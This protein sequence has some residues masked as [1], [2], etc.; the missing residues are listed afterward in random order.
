MTPHESNRDVFPMER[1]SADGQPVIEVESDAEENE[2]EPLKVKA[3]VCMPSAAEVEEHR[4]THLPYRSWCRECVEGRALG[5]KRYCQGRQDEHKIATIGIDYFYMT[6]HSDELL[7]R[8][9]TGFSGTPEG[10]A[11]LAQAIEHGSVVKCV[12][13]KCSA[14]KVITA[15]VV[16]AKG[17]D[18]EGFITRLIVKDIEWIGH[19][20]FLLKADNERSLQRLVRNAMRESKVI[21]EDVDTVAQENPEAYESQSNGM[22]ESAIKTLRGMFRTLRACLQRRLQRK[23]PVSHPISAWLLEHCCM[24]LNTVKR[25]DDG[26]TA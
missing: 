24:L 7:S 13:I 14:T 20:K 18:E 26:L 1:E 5:E 22:T 12:I 16:P 23:V 11:S 17:V 9:G 4:T 25:G 19:S 8:E 10:E 6:E 21:I 2:A 15:H 3:D